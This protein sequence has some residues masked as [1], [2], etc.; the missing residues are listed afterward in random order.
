MYIYGYH[1]ATEPDHILL[2]QILQKDLPDALAC[3]WKMMLCLKTYDFD[4][5][6]SLGCEMVLA[7]ALSCYHSSQHQKWNSTIPS[8]HSSHHQELNLTSPSTMCV[9]H[10]MQDWHAGPHYYWPRIICASPDDG[11]W[12]PRIHSRCA[13]QPLDVPLQYLSPNG[14]R[15]SLPA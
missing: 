9:F 6:Y 2:R 1:F 4:L 14:W 8:T 12:M 15:W 3:L 10:R 7:D 5:T 13:L 11:W